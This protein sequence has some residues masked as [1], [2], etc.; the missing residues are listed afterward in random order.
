MATGQ[1]TAPL[2]LLAGERKTDGSD[3]QLLESFVAE[4]DEVAFTGLIDRHGRL[5]FHL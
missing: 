3:R 2:R 1:F 5:V 4:A